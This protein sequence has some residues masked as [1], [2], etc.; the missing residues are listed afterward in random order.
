[1]LNETK[2]LINDQSFIREWLERINET[3]EAVISETLT[4]MRLDA[5]YREFIMDYARGLK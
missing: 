3:D 5:K 2:K 1:M 4:A